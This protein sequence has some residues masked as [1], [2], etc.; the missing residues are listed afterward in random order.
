MSLA[1]ELKRLGRHSLVYG[2]GGLVSRILA[3]LLLP[4]YT[5]YLTRADYGAIETLIAL[6]AVLVIVL[7]AGISSAF[8]RYYFDANT[9]AERVTVVRTSFWFT[10]TTATAGL[11]AGLVLAE[12]IAHALNGMTP[13]LVRAAFVGLWAR[14]NYEQLTALFRVEE[15]SVQFAMASLANVLV[16]IAATVLLVAV[17]HKGAVGVLI[18]NFTGTLVVYGVLLGYRRYQLGLE[19]NRELFRLMNRFGMPLVPSGLALWAINF[20]DRLFLNTISGAAETGLYSIGVRI[21]SVIIFLFTAFRTAWPAFAYSIEDDREA[22]R[23]YGFV[24][25]Y[26]LLLCSWLS[27]ALGLL[28]PWIVRVLTTP[29]FYAGARVVPL[30]CFAATAYA[31]YTVMAIGIGRV[32]KTQFNWIITFAAAA[33]NIGLNIALI[34]P[35]GMM[36]AAVSTAAA[37]V[38][39]FLLMTWNAQRLYP[40][41]YQWRR[42][43]TLVCVAVALTVLGK[44]LDVPLPVAL[45]LSAV[46]P[47]VLLPLG[48]YLPAER[49]RLRRLVPIFR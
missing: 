4:L 24:L 2:I 7:R 47:L 8:F 14:M 26:L 11:I 39:M 6:T 45:V 19:F 5:H 21:S 29:R 12:P 25:T 22:R 34:P 13:G 10:M 36:G 46:Y 41:P 20:V 44:L 31:G 37:Y 42:V 38:L 32:R 18:G 15:R 35:Y 40:V 48:F 16:T 9:D 33:L 30:L 43:V 49:S 27:V 17:W 3:V 23:T 1:S 28:A